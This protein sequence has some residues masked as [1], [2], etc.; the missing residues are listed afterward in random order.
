MVR[1]VWILRQSC[2]LT[3]AKKLKL[4][5]MK[6]TF[7]NFGLELVEPETDVKLNI[8]D[9]FAATLTFT[10]NTKEHEK[11]SLIKYQ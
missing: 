5:T 2:V 1:V 6:K 3:L 7:E 10:Y 4:K 11:G 9:T 8:S